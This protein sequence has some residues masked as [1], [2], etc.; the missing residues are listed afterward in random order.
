[1][2]AR[3][4]RV[5]RPAS[6][7]SGELGLHLVDDG[8]EGGRIV[9]GQF[10]MLRGNPVGEGYRLIKTGGNNYRTVALPR[11]PGNALPGKFLE[12]LFDLYC[13]ICTECPV[14]RYQDRRGKFVM[15]RLGEQIRRDMSRRAAAVGGVPD[16][17][18]RRRR[19]DRARRRARP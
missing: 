2:F 14:S 17:R 15:F 19:D 5:G 4:T 6:V 16:G 18:L 8:T 9:D 3:T 13:N 1:M 11:F 7:T 10:K 12:L